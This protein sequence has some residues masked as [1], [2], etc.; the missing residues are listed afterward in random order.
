MRVFERI[1]L[2]ALFLFSPLKAAEVSIYD[3]IDVIPMNK[4][5][6]TQ[7]ESGG[8]VNIVIKKNDE[9]AELFSFLKSASP[10]TCNH[11]CKFAITTGGEIISY[12]EGF[13]Y[14][15]LDSRKHGAVQI[16]D[17]SEGEV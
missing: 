13:D 6:M 17:D 10:I 4:V 14:N 15:Q 12:V 7:K 3:L 11:E 9:T 8:G 2:A 1:F 5:A 16:R